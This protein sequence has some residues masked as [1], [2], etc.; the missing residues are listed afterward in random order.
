MDMWIFYLF[1]PLDIFDITGL[2]SDLFGNRDIR[3]FLYIYEIFTGCNLRY[4]GIGLYAH[5][6]PYL[7]Y[8]EIAI[9]AILAHLYLGPAINIWV[10]RELYMVGFVAPRVQF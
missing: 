10:I 5:R 1:H 4:L 9:W 2:K 8:L 7:I 3:P 6:F